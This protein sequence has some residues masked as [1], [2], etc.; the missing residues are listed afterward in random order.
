MKKIV[1]MLTVLLL[2]IG[3][4]TEI[5]AQKPGRNTEPVSIEIPMQTLSDT[6]W[7]QKLLAGGNSMAKT[8]TCND[9]FNFQTTVVQFTTARFSFNLNNTEA[10]VARSRVEVFGPNNFYFWEDVSGTYSNRAYSGTFGGLSPSTNYQWLARVT[11]YNSSNAY[12]GQSSDATQNFTTKACNQ[13]FNPTTTVSGNSVTVNWAG[14]AGISEQSLQRRVNGTTAWTPA[15]LTFNTS[16]TISNLATGVYNLQITGRCKSDI[17]PFPVYQLPTVAGPNFTIRP[18]APSGLTVNAVGYT[19]ARFSWNAVVGATS[20]NISYK[21]FSAT[22]WTALGSTTT[23]SYT[24][25]VGML[26]MGQ[27]YD[28]RVQSVSGGVTSAL[29]A[30]TATIPSFTTLNCNALPNPQA[31]SAIGFTRATLSWTGGT[32]L[33]NFQY[34]RHGTATWTNVQVAG[35]SVTITGLAMGSLYNWQIQSIC[36]NSPIAGDVVTTN[37]VYGST[38]RFNTLT[39][40]APSVYNANYPSVTSVRPAWGAVPYAIN[41][42]LQYRLLGATAWT[43]VNDITALTGPAIPG[44]QGATFEVQAKTSCVSSVDSYESPYSPIVRMSILSCGSIRGSS[45]SNITGS[46]ATLYSLF[47]ISYGLGVAYDFRYK[48]TTDAAWIESYNVP[49]VFVPDP[50]RDQC[51]TC[52]PYDD[53]HGATLNIGGLSA[54]TQYQWQVRSNCGSGIYSGWV[55]RGTFTTIA[56]ACT[57]YVTSAQVEIYE[58]GCDGPYAAPTLWWWVT[59]VTGPAQYEVRRMCST[60]PS[61]FVTTGYTGQLPPGTGDIIGIRVYS[62]AGATAPGPWR[63][64]S[65]AGIGT[66]TNGDP[67]YCDEQFIYPRPVGTTYNCTGGTVARTANNTVTEEQAAVPI[68]KN[69]ANKLMLHGLKLSPNPSSGNF[70]LNYNSD[71]SGNAVLQ[72]TSVSGKT[73]YTQKIYFAKGINQHNISLTGIK[74]GMYTVK[75]QVNHQLITQKMVISN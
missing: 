1:L 19:S 40:S 56:P 27:S 12:I 74:P 67:F 7:Q 62:C 25:P 42:D 69:Q 18:D 30:R 48:K 58:Q 43:S 51:Y 3:G 71:V 23:T 35:T 68:V 33:Y 21:L 57:G 24:F 9:P 16:K 26:Q 29:F 59:G 14:G 8:G 55:D 64:V 31:A 6:E 36:N 39:A 73:V 61:L 44:P 47:S 70:T 49:Y 46:S 41:Y 5:A 20:Y 54:G 10:A 65:I 13:V 66:P 60:A 37:F 11:C 22:A 63:Y 72:I 50:L 28:V 32:G 53:M 2:F 15:T 17:S 52:E 38:T 75:L 45:V 34:Q 4:G